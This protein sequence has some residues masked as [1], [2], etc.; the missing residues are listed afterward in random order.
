M[1]STSSGAAPLLLPNWRSSS[2]SRAEP[3]TVRV[4]MIVVLDWRGRG[5]RP[6]S[7]AEDQTVP[8]RPAAPCSAANSTGSGAAGC[9]AA[10]KIPPPRVEPA[11][12]KDTAGI[13]GVERGPLRAD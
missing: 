4:G 10:F 7:V 11:A 12:E 6:A 2:V 3:G 5:C 8:D 9:T 1:A 13:D